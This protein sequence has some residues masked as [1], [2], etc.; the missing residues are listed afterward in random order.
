MELCK[1]SVEVRTVRVVRSMLEQTIHDMG[2]TV[3][4]PPDV[5]DRIIESDLQFEREGRSVVILRLV[6]HG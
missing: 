6:D 4:V 2:D 3:I 5:F 1:Q